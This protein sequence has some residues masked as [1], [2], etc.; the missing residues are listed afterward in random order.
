MCSINESKVIAADFNQAV[1]DSQ[2]HELD[3]TRISRYVKTI[4]KP[5]ACYPAEHLIQAFLGRPFSNEAFIK[6]I[7]G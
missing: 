5:G 4:L 2:T 3:I 6:N 7:S 1:H